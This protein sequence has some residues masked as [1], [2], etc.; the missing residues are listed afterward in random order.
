MT[1]RGSRS[2]PGRGKPTPAKPASAA[3]MW[4]RP[5]R[6][7]RLAAIPFVCQ[8]DSP[9]RLISPVLLLLVRGST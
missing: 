4:I 5:A 7:P 1:S 3:A 6:A 2:R 8:T 9:S